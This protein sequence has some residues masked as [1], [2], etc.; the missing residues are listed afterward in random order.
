MLNISHGI[1]QHL[2]RNL[3][4]DEK[5]FIH[6][7]KYP[8]TF[9]EHFFVSAS[10]IHPNFPLYNIEKLAKSIN[11]NENNFSNKNKT[12]SVDT[13]QGK[14]KKY[15]CIYC[16]KLVAKIAVHLVKMHRQEPDV[17]KFSLLPKGK[18]ICISIFIYFFCSLYCH[19]FYILTGAIHILK[20]MFFNDLCL[21]LNV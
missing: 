13:C 3:S 8:S 14:S 4:Y 18:F 5:A 1:Y 15:F 21:N 10:N 12:M 16:K 17:T 9:F 7:K 19:N 20:I 6:L 11:H 2:V